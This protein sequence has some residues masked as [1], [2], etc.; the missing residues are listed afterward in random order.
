MAKKRS[1][2]VNKKN[3]ATAA[4]KPASVVRKK[5]PSVISLTRSSAHLLWQHKKV[6]GGI[7]L[8][9][10]LLNLVLVQGLAASTD[11]SS[12][13]DQ[14]N[15][16]F[17]GSLGSVASSLSVFVVLVGS[18]GN[19]SSQTAGAYQFFLA[20]IVSL[21]LIWGL[22]QTFANA[23][24][25]IRDAYYQGM[26]PLVQWILVLLAVGI[27]LLPL[28][29]GASLYSMVISQGIAVGALEQ[30]VWAILFAL[31]SGVSLYF[32][33]A[34]IFALYIVTLPDMTPVKSL[35]S[36][37]D[38][39]SGRRL[40]VFAKLLALPFILLIG[41]AMI[42]I[43]I[44]MLTPTLAQWVFFLLTMTAIAASHTYTYGLY[45]ELLND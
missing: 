11:V 6:F 31:L 30:G 44:I 18:A 17:T 3:G 9:Y 36:A 13:K 41:A 12:L 28:I 8:V 29:I 19:G 20:V 34:S 23:T 43:P 25:R 7:V 22:R 21:A 14:L 27:Q 26:Y 33:T 16:A 1:K 40:V 38:L 42:M 2:T 45:R 37:R 10:G 4:N 24:F 32:I 35:R 5:L 15:S 39:V